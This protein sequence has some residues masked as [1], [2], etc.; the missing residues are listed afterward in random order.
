MASLPEAGQPVVASVVSEF[1]H[2]SVH[3]S[4][5]YLSSDRHCSRTRHTVSLPSRTLNSN[6]KTDNKTID[7]G[8]HEEYKAKRETRDWLT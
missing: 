1:I 5:K 8:R 7:V 3:Q 2:S 6:G 4:D